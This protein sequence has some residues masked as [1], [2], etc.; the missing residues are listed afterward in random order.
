[1]LASCETPGHVEEARALGY[2]AALVLPRR[3]ADREIVLSGVRV[4][5]CPETENR[6]RHCTHCQL[7]WYDRELLRARIT[8]GFVAHGAGAQ[9]VRT[10]VDPAARSQ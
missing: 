1:V 7:C 4:L 8:I 9:F 5:L 2:A 3:P 6:V 10:L